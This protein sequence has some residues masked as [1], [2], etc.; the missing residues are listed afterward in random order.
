MKTSAKIDQ[1]HGRTGIPA[2]L[3]RAAA[4]AVVAGALSVGS[5]NLETVSAHF[6]PPCI[7]GSTALQMSVRQPSMIR[8]RGIAGPMISRIS[9]RI[10][11]GDP[12]QLNYAGVARTD[13]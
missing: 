3:R 1:T 10:R 8:F 12:I 4:V 7:S 2:T 11:P 6:V 13:V 5:P 9:C